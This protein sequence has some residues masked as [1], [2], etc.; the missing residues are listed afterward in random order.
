MD[1][2]LCSYKTNFEPNFSSVKTFNATNIKLDDG[3]ENA[4][5][6][7]SSIHNS[8][9]ILNAPLIKLPSLSPLPDFET[10]FHASFTGEDS[11]F[12][13]PP[14]QVVNLCGL[15]YEDSCS[16]DTCQF[17]TKSENDSICLE[18]GGSTMNEGETLSLD[19]VPKN[20]AS[21]DDSLVCTNNKSNEIIQPKFITYKVT[22]NGKIP[23]EML[24]VLPEKVRNKSKMRSDNIKDKVKTHFFKFTFGVLNEM[25]KKY[26]FNL[27]FINI[28][29]SIKNTIKF[30]KIKNIKVESIIQ[31]QNEKRKGLN[32]SI[33]Y[34]AHLYNKVKNIPNFKE[35]FN[36]TLYE[37][38][39]VYY[40]NSNLEQLS[41]KFSLNLN[42]NKSKILFF[43]DF[44]NEN[45]NEYAQMAKNV[46]D[47]I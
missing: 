13:D 20:C 37:L 27:K 5:E 42:K 18:N 47:T 40:I 1:S 45:Y 7:L 43:R 8:R 28:K 26:G 25:T 23:K 41:K 11:C 22:K 35:I 12:N 44:L 33:N 10:K 9:F 32:R 17:T 6:E 21:E 16:A 34:N 39:K 29:R 14:S 4:N 19:N 2:G 15:S 30:H 3:T 31:M 46:V 36:M 38:F 24:S